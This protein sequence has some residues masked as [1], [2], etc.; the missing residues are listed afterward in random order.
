MAVIIPGYSDFASTVNAAPATYFWEIIAQEELQ[1]GSSSIA[2]NIITSPS[3]SVFTQAEVRY[4]IYVWKK[5]G[6]TYTNLDSDKVRVVLTQSWQDSV[7]DTVRIGSIVSEYD[8]HLRPT[9][10]NNDRKKVF[11]VGFKA[12]KDSTTFTPKFLVTLKPGTSENSGVDHLEILPSTA[13]GHIGSTLGLTTPLVPTITFTAAKVE[14]NIPKAVS[15]VA[16][17]QSGNYI[18]QDQ[19]S[20]PKRWVVLTSKPDINP[21]GTNYYLF[22]YS[23][24]GA[25]H[26]EELIGYTSTTKPTDAFQKAEKK[27]LEFK[28]SDCGT[29]DGGL[30]GTVPPPAEPTSDLRWNPPSHRD[31]RDASFGQR[32]VKPSNLHATQVLQTYASLAGSTSNLG[33]IYQDKNGGAVLNTRLKLTKDQ[34]P[35]LWG[36]R[37]MYNPENFTYSTSANN[38]VDWGLGAK[39]PAVLLAGNQT[40][41]FKIYLNRIRDMS[42]LLKNPGGG[43]GYYRP[44]KDEEVK[45]ILN[46]GTEYDIEFLYRVLNGDPEKGN[47]LL[48]S[49]YAG[50]TADFGYTTGTPCWL[51][52]GPN[53]KYFGSVTGFT[54]SHAMFTENMI[55]MLTVVDISFN[56]YPAIWSTSDAKT[57]REKQATTADSTTGT[58]TDATGSVGK[59]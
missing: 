12:K 56:R 43:S 7:A 20:T 36:F 35:A 26:T 19:C 25:S 14:P 52:L 9:A 23:L 34:G 59:P 41:S 54:V 10:V 28:V 37:F 48:S 39:D 3:K 17:K 57:F 46:R 1:I 47:P 29:I 55:P 6:S 22:Y 45:G 4:S 51:Q 30:G 2:Y 42:W 32:M 53:I 24:D 13:P 44:L 31:T 33:K 38:S 40:V 5:V 27:F 58:T 8:T 11:Y 49:T 15:A 50:E 21:N 18:T 16:F